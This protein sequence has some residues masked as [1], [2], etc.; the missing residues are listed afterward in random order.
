[1]DKIKK[2]EHYEIL[3]KMKWYYA[4]MPIIDDFC[5]ITKEEIERERERTKITALFL[6]LQRAILEFEQN[7]K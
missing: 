4:S 3:N 6:D 1:M 2:E 7:D 5:N